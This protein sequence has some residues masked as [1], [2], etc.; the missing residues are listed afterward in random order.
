VPHGDNHYLWIN[1]SDSK[2]MI[3]SNDGGS[4]ITFDGG[5]SWST[6]KN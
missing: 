6:Q 3:N 2:N 1:P 4:N 5:L